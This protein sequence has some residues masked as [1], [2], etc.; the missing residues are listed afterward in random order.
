MPPLS[1]LPNLFFDDLI[2]IRLDAGSAPLEARAK[3]ALQG[4]FQNRWDHN[5]SSNH[6]PTTHTAPAFPTFASSKQSVRGSSRR[7]PPPRGTSWRSREWNQG[8]WS[9]RS[10]GKA[11]A[12][13]LGGAPFHQARS[14]HSLRDQAMA[15]QTES[16]M[17]LHLPLQVT[18]DLLRPHP[19]PTTLRHTS[20]AQRWGGVAVSQ[21][22]SPPPA[23]PPGQL[24]HKPSDA[25][26]GAAGRGRRETSAISRRT[27]PRGWLARS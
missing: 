4:P 2:L 13:S 7:W 12:L 26:R 20:L 25:V 16:R 17:L 18:L 1:F 3:A 27:P 11:C 24:Q 14:S 23:Q 22:P 15:G 21:T 9:G 10:V 8:T 6:I 5:D 19:G